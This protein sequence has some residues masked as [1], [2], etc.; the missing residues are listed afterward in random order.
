MKKYIKHL[1]IT[2]IVASVIVSP[3]LSS[4]AVQAAPQILAQPLKQTATCWAWIICGFGGGGGGG[5]GSFGG[6]TSKPKPKKQCTDCG[7][8][9]A[10]LELPTINLTDEQKDKVHGLLEADV[11]AAEAE[12]KKLNKALSQAEAAYEEA[13]K[14][15]KKMTG[16]CRQE[17]NALA[18]KVRTLKINLAKKEVSVDE[19]I[20]A[21][22]KFKALENRQA[23][24]QALK[25]Y[26]NAKT[27][28]G[29][30]IA[31]TALTLALSRHNT[32]NSGLSVAQQQLLSSRESLNRWY[33]I[34]P[35][36]PRSKSFALVQEGYVSKTI[37]K[38]DCSHLGRA[39]I[40]GNG[41]ARNGAQKDT[42][43]A[44]FCH[45]AGDTYVVAEPNDY[46]KSGNA[47]VDKAR[48]ALATSGAI[49]QRAPITVGSSGVV[50]LLTSGTKNDDYAKEC[51]S[52]GYTRFY[53]KMCNGQCVS[54][55]K[56][57]LVKSGV[58]PQKF[59][60]L[61]DGK[62][63]TGTLGGMG[64][65]VD[66]TPAVG[67]VFSRQSGGGGSGHTGIVSKVYSDGSI[68]VEDYNQVAKAT[69]GHYKVS[70][71]AVQSGDY[72]FAHVETAVK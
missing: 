32:A 15:C 55:V 3:L 23:Y 63:V 28:A 10:R 36:D 47:S 66:R 69:Y 46:C 19:A 50:G 61:G 5:G 40:P 30:K 17:V 20:V 25:N 54:F 65:K 44:G 70:A 29:K 37:S 39:W 12:A 4:S 26:Q 71:A 51:E 18:R 43:G 13:K 6:A 16:A 21:A 56:F 60:A 1:L 7:L 72:S 62:Y 53:A 41:C 34:L 49:M 59:V 9:G 38:T 48:E 35:S 45:N 57:R 33:G 2:T 27:E 24:E 22:A 42:K 14:L 52:S 8:L 64:H 58:L 31:L 11:A 68:E 67:S